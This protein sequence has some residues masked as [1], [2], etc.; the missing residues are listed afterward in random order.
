MPVVEFV[1]APWTNTASEQK[2]RIWLPRRQPR[3]MCLAVGV[4]S[5]NSVF[6]T[7]IVHF[8]VVGHLFTAFV[9]TQHRYVRWV[10][11]LKEFHAPDFTA[12]GFA[13]QAV[14]ITLRQLQPR[15]ERVMCFDD[16]VN[17]SKRSCLR[18]SRRDP[19]LQRLVTFGLAGVELASQIK[20]RQLQGPK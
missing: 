6:V 18:V 20:S 9:I 17:F 5:A 11:K 16:L 7:V 14:Q 15:S 1:P 8:Q 19:I 3:S 4:R 10:M 12:T 13:A 2:I